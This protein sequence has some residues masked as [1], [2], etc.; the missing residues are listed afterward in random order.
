M[1]KIGRRQ[2]TLEV[3][4]TILPNVKEER[5]L[6]P[7][8][9][10]S[11]VYREM[12]SLKRNGP[13]AEKNCCNQRRKERRLLCPKDGANKPTDHVDGWNGLE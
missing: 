4:E 6:N 9:W 10:E 12:E 11:G 3:F 5:W 13:M 7:G 2:S 1:R 8:S